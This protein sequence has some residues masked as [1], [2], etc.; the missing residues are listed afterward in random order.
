[1]KWV[2][3]TLAGVGLVGGGLAFAYLSPEPGYSDEE[4]RAFNFTAYPEPRLIDG[5]ELVDAHGARFDATRLRERWSFVFFRIREL[6]RHLPDYHG[7]PRRGR[8]ASA[9]RLVTRHFEACS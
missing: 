8:G 2:L 6:S 7:G 5:F 4:L 9:S 3:A 1:M